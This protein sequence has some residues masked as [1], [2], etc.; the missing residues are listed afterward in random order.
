MLAMLTDEKKQQY[1]NKITA[2]QNGKNI[3]TG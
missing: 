2:H 3:L 1:S